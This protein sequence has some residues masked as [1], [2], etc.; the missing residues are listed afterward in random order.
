MEQKWLLDSPVVEGMHRLH[1]LTSARICIRTVSTAEP[2]HWGSAVPPL[3]RRLRVLRDPASAFSFS[4]EMALRC[5]LA[6]Y[7]GSAAYAR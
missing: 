2:D 3:T 5:A 7:P 4:R 1:E 6:M